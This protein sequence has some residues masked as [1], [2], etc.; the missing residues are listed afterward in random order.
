MSKSKSF[1]GLYASITFLLGGN[2]RHEAGH[3]Y[4]NHKTAENMFL[5]FVKDNAAVYNFLV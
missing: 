1:Q 2:F 4:G 3:W 5:L